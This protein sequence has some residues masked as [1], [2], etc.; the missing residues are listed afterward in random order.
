M[1][2]KIISETTLELAFL[3]LGAVFLPENFFYVSS[4]EKDLLTGKFILEI[5]HTGY[6]KMEKML[7]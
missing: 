7:C 3:I 6:E 5:G 2:V 4:L 1:D